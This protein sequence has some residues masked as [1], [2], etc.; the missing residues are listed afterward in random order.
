M[1]GKLRHLRA[2]GRKLRHLRARGRNLRH[3]RARGRKLRQKDNGLQKQQKVN[4][5]VYE[6]LKFEC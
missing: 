2:R 4:G 6:F 3:L 5:K 1:V